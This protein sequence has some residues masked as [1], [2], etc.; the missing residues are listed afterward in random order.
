VTSVDA[1]R[2][3]TSGPLGVNLFV[4]QPS[5]DASAEFAAYAAALEPDAKR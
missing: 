5:T 4:P 2:R 1:A 3:L